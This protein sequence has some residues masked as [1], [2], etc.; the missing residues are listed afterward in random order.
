MISR[1][2][3]EKIRQIEDGSKEIPINKHCPIAQWKAQYAEK[4]TEQSIESE[5]VLASKHLVQNHGR[6]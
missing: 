1:Y 2:F 3:K 6:F 4:S 5:S